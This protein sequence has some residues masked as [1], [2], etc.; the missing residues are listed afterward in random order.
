MKLNY[1]LTISFLFASFILTPPLDASGRSNIAVLNFSLYNT[2]E[3][4]GNILRSKLE[5][6]FYAVNRYN[7]LE[8]NRLEILEKE[9]KLSGEKE[10]TPAYA[11][12]MGRLLKSDYIITGTIIFN[13]TYHLN[14]I[15]ADVNSGVIIYSHNESFSDENL[16]YGS[17]RRL[18]LD[19]IEALESC[20]D[21][22]VIS[23]SRD[24]SSRQSAWNYSI[25]AGVI[26]GAPRMNPMLHT[27]FYVSAGAGRIF[28]E[29][30]IFAGISA[31]YYHFYITD[32]SGYAVLAPV[33]A[34]AG[35]IAVFSERIIVAP[36]IS[37][38]TAFVY[39]TDGDTGNSAF[40]PFLTA[41]LSTGYRLS[42]D[43]SLL[44]SAGYN[45][46]LED[47][48]M[49]DFVSFSAGISNSFR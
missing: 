29:T 5:Y 18:S 32:K 14:I 36:S 3:R 26:P 7:I 30:G 15:L 34:A 37:A 20:H 31:G 28:R 6:E 22:I 21:N 9:M 24:K 33:Q 46:L 2:P 27:G 25:S 47:D 43:T 1:S 38:G 42:E 41:V 17:S 11:L 49:I 40:E 13:G 44:V 39:L 48:G 12:T 19:M 35:Y 16:L 8:R 23:G 45:M 10:G 4:I